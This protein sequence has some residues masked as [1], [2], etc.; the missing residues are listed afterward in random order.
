VERNED[1]NTASSNYTVGQPD[2]TLTAFT[3]TPNTSTLGTAVTLS[4]TE[5]N[6]GAAGAG[7]HFVAVW[8]DRPSAPNPPIWGDYGWQVTS[9]NAGASVTNTWSYTPGSPGLKRGWALADAQDTV[10]ETNDWNNTAYYEYAT[11]SVGHQPDLVV[12]SLTVSP[13]PSTLGT[14]VTLSVT[15]QN[16]GTG[17]A[18]THRLSA[19]G[20]RA[21]PPAVGTN[22][23]S[24]WDIPSLVPGASVTKTWSY[25]PGYVAARTA[26][27]LADALGAVAESNETNNGKSYAYSVTAA[28][29][30]LIVQSLTVSPN[31]AAL[32]T[33]VTLSVTEQNVGSVAAGAHRLSAWGNRTTAPAVGTNG[34]SNW[35]I[36]SLA[37]GASE[38]RT[39]SYRPGF[40][41][42]RTAQALADALGAVAESN[43]GNNTKSYAYSITAAAP[44]L[45]V[46]SLAVSPNPST[47]GT[48]VTLT[49]TEQNVGTAAAGAH[50]L[51]AWGNRATA[52]AV[53]TSGDSNWDI[54]SLAAGAS[55]T[56][57]WSYTPGYAWPRT[58]RARA[59]A[60]GAVAESNEGNNTASYAYVVN[61]VGGT[62]ASGRPPRPRLE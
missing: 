49:V 35:D 25:Q 62:S 12:Q 26:R 23:D 30:D 45:I 53:G 55:E 15:E 57:T 11:N 28:A 60:L 14:Q 39:W 43:E 48:Q 13:N 8:V 19:W 21:S 17:A 33:Q 36:A 31:P 6:I 42:P 44:D 7:E 50:R 56:R 58:A 5:K 27:A 37:A 24:N 47:L 59:D 2:L 4:V 10:V 9:L 22:G 1:N 20:N 32:G 61:P 52:P 41:W 51:S 54:A 34:D 29:P 3:V 18:G 40:A 16:T 46:Q 38:T